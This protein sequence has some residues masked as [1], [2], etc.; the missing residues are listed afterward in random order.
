MHSTYP[1]SVILRFKLLKE[2]VQHVEFNSAFDKTPSFS[3]EEDP[4]RHFASSS[5][6]LHFHVFVRGTVWRID[7]RFSRVS[8]SSVEELELGTWDT[9]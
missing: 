8:S 3:E 7:N 2:H 9:A 1:P 4:F 5:L 6:R